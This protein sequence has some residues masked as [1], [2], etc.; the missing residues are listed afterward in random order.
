LSGGSREEAKRVVM[1]VSGASG[2]EEA[3]GGGGR[4][5]AAYEAADLR[6]V[7]EAVGDFLDR[8]RGPLRELVSIMLTVMDGAQLGED[9][10]NFYRRLKDSGMPDDVA[11]EMTRQ[12][13]RE[14]LQ[15]A[16]LANMLARLIRREL[17]GEE[18]EEEGE[19]KS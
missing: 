3:E 15:A 11:L 16:N 13:F 9:V 8:L 12:Y 5:G 19:A 2:S 10:A 14:R 4:G 6:A 17:M 1:D 7:L 18:E